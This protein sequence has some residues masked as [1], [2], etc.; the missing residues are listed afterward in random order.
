MSSDNIPLF[1]RLE[2]SL[3]IGYVE[4]DGSVLMGADS[5]VSYAGDRFITRV[6]KIKKFR[7]DLIVG[8]VGHLGP[9][10]RL[11]SSLKVPPRKPKDD[12][13]KWLSVD[14]VDE[15]RDCMAD[16]GSLRDSE[17]VES[18]GVDL[19]IAYRGQLAT[20]DSGVSVM[21]PEGKYLAIGSG[22]D[23]AMGALYVLEDSDLT[24]KQKVVRALDSAAFHT[25]Y[26]HPP[27]TFESIKGT[28]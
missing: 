4:D 9:L 11:F 20:I 14:L 1:R 8:G 23:H 26:V 17:S 19:L 27:Y 6:P 15:I 10:M 12:P 2:L 5:V 24:A 13:V 25:L 3:V 21:A 22:Q 18:V 7:K 28:T 16:A